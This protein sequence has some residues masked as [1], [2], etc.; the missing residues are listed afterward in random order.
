MQVLPRRKCLAL[1]QSS[2]PQSAPTDR[3]RSC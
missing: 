2:A 1:S 3:V